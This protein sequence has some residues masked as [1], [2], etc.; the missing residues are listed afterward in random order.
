M[1][2]VSYLSVCLH[3]LQELSQQCEREVDVREPELTETHECVGRVRS[4]SLLLS[5]IY[6]PPHQ[7]VHCV[8]S[9]DTRTSLPVGM[10]H[11]LHT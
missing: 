5:G 1:R 11:H 8:L 7:D 3:V 4:Q 2:A 9:Q 10:S 6:V